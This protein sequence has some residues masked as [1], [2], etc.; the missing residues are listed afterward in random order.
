MKNAEE[1]QKAKEEQAKVFDQ[2]LADLPAGSQPKARVCNR[3]YGTTLLATGVM[4][5]ILWLSIGRST[6]LVIISIILILLFLATLILTPNTPVFDIYDDFIV[7]YY[8]DDNKRICIIPANR[9][10]VWDVHNDES[11]YVQFLVGDPQLPEDTT[12]QT[13]VTVPTINFNKA[14][15]VLNKYY[16]DKFVRQAKLL[17]Y[18]KEHA[19]KKTSVKERLQYIGGLFTHV[20]SGR[21]NDN[22]QSKNMAGAKQPDLDEQLTQAEEQIP[23][24]QPIEAETPTPVKSKKTVTKSTTAKKKAPAKTTTAKKATKS[25]A[26]KNSTTTKA[27]PATKTKTK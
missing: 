18:Q 26:V 5:G 15:S 16:S 25:T 4:V 17:R 23:T 14:S 21:T 11:A 12:Q 13:V 24:E 2:T 20:F 27:K 10:V 9:L 22:I 1:F 3:P 8:H 6:P 7:A 19:S